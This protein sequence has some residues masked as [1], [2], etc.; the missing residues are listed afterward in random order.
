MFSPSNISGT[1]AV[2]GV[3][4]VAPSVPGTKPMRRTLRD[5]LRHAADLA[6]AFATLADVETDAPSPRSPLGETEGPTTWDAAIGLSAEDAGSVACASTRATEDDGRRA[7]TA[8]HPHRVPLRASARGGR[9]GAVVARH[10]HCL[11]PVDGRHA[12]GALR[13]PKRRSR[14]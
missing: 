11:T 3:T 8:S 12:H 10:Q 13:A 2:G 1:A 4:G 7:E 6:V 5:T 14:V 9:P